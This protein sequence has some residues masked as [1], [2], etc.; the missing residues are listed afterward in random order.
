MK[1]ELNVN[2]GKKVAEFE[3]A[4]KNFRIKRVL[5]KRIFRGKGLEFDGYRLHQIDD[6]ANSID[7]KASLRT[8]QLV[9]KQYVEER[10]L[11]IIFVIDVGD[12]MVSGSQEK[13]K[14][15]YSAEICAALSHLIITSGD[16]I[17]GF[18][19]N[20][21]IS[22]RINMGGG[23]NQFYLFTNFLKKGE[24]YGGKSNFDYILDYL[25]KT[26][27]D[28]I[29]AVIIISDFL[30]LK[31]KNFKRLKMFSNRFETMGIIIEDPLDMTMPNI[32]SQIV[33]E[34]S[35][36]GKQI[37]IDPQLIKRRYEKFALEHKNKVKQ[38]FHNS[39]IDFV[40][41]S[42]DKSFVIP[43]ISFLK[44]MVEKSKY[45]IPLK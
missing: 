37:L 44:E 17:G 13:L 35:E 40:Q 43:L 16:K 26:L 7:W 33:I 11:K 32:K 23:L 42:T 39:N 10:N 4:M 21:K 41:L 22:K 29:S 9:E 5:Y 3:A 31:E 36:T 14:C 20:D 34:D 38:M 1:G 18:L 19:F 25:G 12:N 27:D 6:D 45:I 24:N 8:N 30:R 2:Y 28:S 15:E